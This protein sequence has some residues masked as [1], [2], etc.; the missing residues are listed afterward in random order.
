MPPKPPRPRKKH[1]LDFSTCL[2]NMQIHPSITRFF[3]VPQSD[4]HLNNSK[5][6][7]ADKFTNDYGKIITIF[8]FFS[9]NGYA[10]LYINGLLQEGNIFSVNLNEL[11]IKAIGG[12]ISAGTPIILEIVKFSIKKQ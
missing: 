3:Y 1:S 5:I 11:K 8:P 9:K 7:Y 4:I 2:K 6:I 12:T 10:N